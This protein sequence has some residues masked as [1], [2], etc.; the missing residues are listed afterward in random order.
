MLTGIVNELFTKVIPVKFHNTI[1][2]KKPL[3]APDIIGCFKGTQT[4]QGLVAPKTETL[5]AD[6]ERDFGTFNSQ[7]GFN[8]D[9]IKCDRLR[10]VYKFLVP[11]L[12]PERP[13]RVF[14]KDCVLISG[15][16]YGTR[17]AD[18]SGVMASTINA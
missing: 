8:L 16:F 7:N 14:K 5:P 2:G 3:T 1:R 9:H 18:W 13:N 4:G 15:S 12:N 11:I 17:P 10:A 6:Q